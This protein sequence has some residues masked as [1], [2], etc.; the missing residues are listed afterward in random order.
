MALPIV[1]SDVQQHELVVRGLSPFLQFGEVGLELL[2]D[3]LQSLFGFVA[4]G[5]FAFA[6]LGVEV[7]QRAALA[8]ECVGERIQLFVELGAFG[9]GLLIVGLELYTVV[10]GQS[11]GVDLGDHR[12]GRGDD[13]VEVL[14]AVG[15]AVQPLELLNQNREVVRV[16]VEDLLGQAVEVFRF[17]VAMQLGQARDFQVTDCLSQFFRLGLFLFF[18]A[19]AAAL[20]LALAGLA[21]GTRMESGKPPGFLPGPSRL[22]LPCP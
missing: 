22:L 17:F 13:F 1:A 16:G 10:L 7:A 5:V 6:K 11:L 14:L 15:F 4:I 19:F 9:L 20:G 8:V 18:F 2:V 3:L 12:V 21:G